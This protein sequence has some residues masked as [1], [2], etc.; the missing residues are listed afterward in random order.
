MPIAALAQPAE[1]LTLG[2]LV[3]LVLGGLGGGGAILTV[4][5]LVFAI[6]ES[7]ADAATSSLVIVGMAAATGA[8][9]HLRARRVDWRSGLVFGLAG[10]PAAL[11]G[12]RLS[13]AVDGRV[14][15]SVFAIVMVAAAASMA[16]GVLSR[17]SAACSRPAA[18]EAADDAPGDY[19]GI[20]G[21]SRAGTTLLERTVPS[22]TTPQRIRRPVAVLLSGLGVGLLTG[23]LGV[24][25]GFVVV[26]ALVL[27]LGLPMELA[28]GTSL[29]V[30]VINTL[31]SLVARMPDL[32]VDLAV[33]APFAAA[34]MIATLMGRRLASRLP[35]AQL[36]LAFAG[37]LVLVA[38]YT[39]LKVAT[40]AAA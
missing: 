35:T 22:T 6:G 2:I 29:V 34:A 36:Q 9:S 4:P 33:T 7:P 26:P 12:S 23:F 14:L 8:V 32:H 37:L 1:L 19:A 24:G 13:G 27:V 5:L 18:S 39:L 10:V 17:G 20:A 11:V 16:R 38:G 30:V 28:V 31:A 15:M 21:A 40:G 25:G 3:G